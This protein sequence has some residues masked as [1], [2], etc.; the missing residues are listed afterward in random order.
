[1]KKENKPSMAMKI[2]TVALAGVVGVVAGMGG[3]MLFAP[4]PVDVQALEA[5]AFDNGAASVVIPEP[6]VVTETVTE[7][8]EVV[9]PINDELLEFAQDAIDEDLTVDYIMFENEAKAIAETYIEEDLIS[10]LKDLDYFEDGEVFENYRKSEVTIKKIYDVDVSDRDFEDKDA[11]L[12]YEVKL[13]AKESG[14]SSEY[15]RFEVEFPF[16]DGELDTDDIEISLI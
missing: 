14:E 2:G 13:K 16:E 4:E 12:T 1:M 6:T 15:V 3:M 10:E 11:V 5:Q 7:I 8:K 9:N